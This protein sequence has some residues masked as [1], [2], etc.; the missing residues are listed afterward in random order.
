MIII[1]LV[2]CLVLASSIPAAIAFE[3]VFRHLTGDNT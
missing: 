3:V 1:A 2:F